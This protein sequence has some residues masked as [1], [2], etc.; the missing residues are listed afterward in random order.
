MG[1][2]WTLVRFPARFCGFCGG[3]YPPLA[4]DEVKSLHH[5]NEVD[6]RREDQEAR[7]AHD[8]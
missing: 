8:R 5:W 1:E 2:T 7:R 4:P 3:R 6:E